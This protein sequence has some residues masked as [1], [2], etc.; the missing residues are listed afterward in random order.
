MSADV[1]LFLSHRH[2]KSIEIVV[3]EPE[4]NRPLA[5]SW[6]RWEDSLK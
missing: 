3:R 2:E 1:K 4:G 6:R 5:G